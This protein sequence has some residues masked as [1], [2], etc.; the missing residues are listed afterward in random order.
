MAMETDWT[1][2]LSFLSSN[3]STFPPLCDILLQIDYQDHEAIS[4]ECLQFLQKTLLLP[5]REGWQAGPY[6]YMAATNLWDRT[7]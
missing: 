1:R 7:P 4:E 2:N 3:Y 5:L 6:S